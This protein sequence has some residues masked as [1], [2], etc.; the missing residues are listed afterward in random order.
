MSERT[1]V[2][3]GPP[4]SYEEALLRFPRGM[5]LTVAMYEFKQLLTSPVLDRLPLTRRI[6]EVS[7]ESLKAMEEISFRRNVDSVGKTNWDYFLPYC[8][9]EPLS[10]V[11]EADEL[12]RELKI[13]TLR[14]EVRDDKFL[15]VCVLADP[16]FHFDSPEYYLG[17]LR[18]HEYDLLIPPVVPS[19][20]SRNP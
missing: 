15:L 6:M 17:I 7:A 20:L 10:S 12:F 2:N 18:H 4:Q 13:W 19:S 3:F 16:G 9:V 14:P 1:T 11:F 8:R 5:D